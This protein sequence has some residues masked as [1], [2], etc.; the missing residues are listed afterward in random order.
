MRCTL[1]FRCLGISPDNI[2]E[3]VNV[4][5]LNL[6][7]TVAFSGVVLFIGYGLRRLVRPLEKYKNLVSQRWQR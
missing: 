1:N 7:H 6:I 4:L 2:A 3:K 5:K